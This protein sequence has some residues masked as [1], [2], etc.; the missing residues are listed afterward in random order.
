MIHYIHVIY[1]ISR[2]RQ[3]EDYVIVI[4]LH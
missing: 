3:N 2:H 4:K 1:T